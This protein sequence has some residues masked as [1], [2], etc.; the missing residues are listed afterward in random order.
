MRA[1]AIIVACLLAGVGLVNPTRAAT[2]SAVLSTAE[3]VSTHAFNLLARN[4]AARAC[5]D[6]WCVC[7]CVCVEREHMQLCSALP[8]GITFVCGLSRQPPCPARY[9]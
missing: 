6:G 2:A 8:E 1:T 7:V 3:E 5:L 9:H 4:A